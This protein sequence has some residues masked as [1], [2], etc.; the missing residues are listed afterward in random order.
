MQ[1][2]NPI[3]LFDSG[4]GGTTI[5]REVKQ[6]MPYED[7][8][9][10]GD[11]LN[12]PYGI[13][14]KDE[15]VQLSLKNVEYL[16]NQNC[17][18]IIVACNTATTNAVAE[19][20]S[21]FTIPIIGIEP[22]IK[23]ATSLTKTSTIGILATKGTITSDFFASKIKLYPNIKI[24]EQIG[25]NLVNLIESGKTNTEEMRMLLKEYLYPMVEQGMDTLVLGCTHYPY[26]KPL[27]Q[28]IIGEDILIIDS[29][30]AVAKHTQK[31]LE[32]HNLLT[33]KTTD[34]YSKFYTNI[35]PTILQS[36]LADPHIAEYKDF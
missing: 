14:S 7:T 13:K 23:P 34:G 31:V 30:K 16:I 26:L 36:F 12:A 19:I 25:Y 17:K 18:L 2:N 24:I 10:I 8:I 9:F 28:D 21:M 22:A 3:G 11:Q 15:I 29:G 4:I 6:L 35:E 1:K 20:R 27:I 33:D 32:Q 5:W